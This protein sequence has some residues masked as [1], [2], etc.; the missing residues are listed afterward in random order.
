[1]SY[2]TPAGVLFGVEKYKNALL[3]VCAERNITVD[4]FRHLTEIDAARKEVTFEHVDDTN[5]PKKTET[6]KVERFLLPIS[7]FDSF[8]SNLLNIS[9]DECFSFEMK[10]LIE[11]LKTN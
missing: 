11:H 4:L 6:L 5:T 8:L 10:N 9:Y 1:M 2:K 7:F 3:K